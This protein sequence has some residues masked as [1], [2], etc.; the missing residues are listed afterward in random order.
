MV[1]IMRVINLELL[2]QKAPLLQM[3]GVL[4]PGTLVFASI[5]AQAQI[6]SS[7]LAACTL[8]SGAALA[9]RYVYK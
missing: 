2:L 4:L 6:R 7:A 1:I 3:R 9:A 5:G 8:G